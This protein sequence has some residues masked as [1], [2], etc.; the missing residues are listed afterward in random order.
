MS[1]AYSSSY[2][3]SCSD[4][5]D[6][7]DD[8]EE[9]A[10]SSYC[11]SD[12]PPEQSD[13]PLDKSQSTSDSLKLSDEMFSTTKR[14]LAWRENFSAHM[15]ATASEVSLS[16]SLK[17]KINLEDGDAV[18]H[19]SSLPYISLYLPGFDA[20]MSRSSKR[21]RSQT[22][23]GDA[24]VLS[25]GAH[26]CPACDASFMTLQSLRQHGYDAKA[27]EA[28]CVAVEYALE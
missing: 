28:C 25:L 24:S 7:D 9:S 15:S 2:S 13:S 19:P 17:R 18:S 8:E 27:N 14:I 21:S 4:D 3:S 10:C 11:S 12:L 22:S 16:S 23:Q 20:Q 5:D 26:S 1:S 6:E